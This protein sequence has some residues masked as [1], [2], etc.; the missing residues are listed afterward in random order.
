MRVTVRA[1]VVP[2]YR[3]LEFHP[4]SSE[5]VVPVNGHWPSSTFCVTLFTVGVSRKDCSDSRENPKI[6]PPHPAKRKSS[7]T[8]IIMSLVG[9]LAALCAQGRHNEVL[10]TKMDRLE[11]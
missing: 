6:S 7:P 3:R 9:I 2:Q 1:T 4:N 10:G 11:K 5:V 8:K